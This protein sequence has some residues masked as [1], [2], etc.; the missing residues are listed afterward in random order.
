MKLHPY[1]FFFFLLRERRDSHS[2]VIGLRRTRSHHVPKNTHTYT[3]SSENFHDSCPNFHLHFVPSL[4]TRKIRRYSA[5]FVNE[6]PLLE[7]TTLL[8]VSTQ[9]PVCIREGESFD[10][11]EQGKDGELNTTSSFLC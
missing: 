11:E 2:H 3:F 7:T 8:V 6:Q 9:Q 1:D 10:F 5:Q 4:D